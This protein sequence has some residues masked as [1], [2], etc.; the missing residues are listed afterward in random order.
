MSLTE[1]LDKNLVQVIPTGLGGYQGKCLEIIIKNTTAQVLSLEIP[2]GQLFASADSNVQD[3]V[4]TKSQSLALAPRETERKQLYTMC[5]QAGNISPSQGTAFSTGEMASLPLQRLVQRIDAGN[6]QN[7]TAQSAVWSI[8]N[9]ESVRQIYGED[10]SMVQDLAQIV[11]EERNISID[12]FDL[13]PRRHQITSIKSSLEV[14]LDQDLS[15][16]RLMLVDEQGSI[17]RTYFDNRFYEQGFH[18]W[19]VGASHTLGDSAILFLR[20]LDGE[21]LV[22]QKKVSITD[23]ITTLK[24]IHTQS[25]MSYEVARDLKADIGIYDHE[26]HLYFLIKKDHLIK[27]GVHRGQYIAKCQL[28]PEQDYFF[29]VLSGTEVLASEK[30]GDEKPQL[31]PK[32]K[33]RGAFAI[34]LKQPLDNAVLAIYDEERKVKRILY[35]IRHLNPGSR[36]FTYT[37]EHR[38]GPEAKFYIRLVDQE[39]KTVEE[40][41]VSGK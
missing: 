10:V 31:F 2:A 14:L 27:K 37:F 21:E 9:K 7:S 18:Q 20:L 22:A 1:A 4:I 32:M 13:S 16:A 25:I 19:K 39:G 30:V 35:N 5:T 28:P 6:Y 23:S 29:K 17:V 24:D 33:V 36:Q 34:T 38:S 11:S 8:S 12:D 40:K 15:H 26:N 41:Q 3:L